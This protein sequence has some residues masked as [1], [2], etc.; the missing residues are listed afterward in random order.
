[1]KKVSQSVSSLPEKGYFCQKE[2]L[3]TKKT[4]LVTG[5]SKGIGRE[6]ACIPPL[7]KG[8]R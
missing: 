8:R 7:A 6:L 4:A 2:S 1:M 5:A 3:M